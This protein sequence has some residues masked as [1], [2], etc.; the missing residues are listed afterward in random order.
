MNDGNAATHTPLWGTPPMNVDI[1]TSVFGFDQAGAMGNIMFVR[2][3]MINK[4]SDELDS[5]FVSMWHDDDVG[6]A[7]DD[8]VGCNID[9]SVGYTYNDADGDNT[10]GVEVPAAGADFFQGPLVSSPGDTST[11]FTWSKEKSYH[12]RDFP[13]MKRLG[14]TSFAKYIN[15][16][17]IF[18]D[19]ASAQETY[20][21]MNGLVGTTGEPFIDPTTGQPSIFVHDGDPTNGTGWLD[22]VP[23]DRRY[24]MTSGP[25]YFAPGDTQE[26]VGALILAAGSN[27]AKSITKMLYF[28][29]FA[30][31]AFDANF[32]VCSPPSPSPVLAQLDKKVILSFEEG[33]DAVEAYNCGSYEFQGYNVYQG[34]SFNGPWTRIKT[35]DVVD[36]E[37]ILLDLSLDEDTGELLEI[38]SQFGSDSGLEHYIEITYDKLNSR[39]LINNRKYYFS[40]TAYAYDPAAAQRVIESPIS[41]IVAVPGQPGVGSA[42]ASTYADT[43]SITHQSGIA[44]AVFYPQIVDP[45]LLTGNEYTISVYEASD[46]TIMWKLE[47]ETESLFSDM[48]LFPASSDYYDPLA[49]IGKADHLWVTRTITDGFL[50]TS[51]KTTFDAPTTYASAETTQDDNEETSLDFGGIYVGSPDGTWAGFLETPAAGSL[52]PSGRPGKDQLQLDIEIRFTEGGSIATYFDKNIDPAN[53]DTT[54][55]PFEVWTVED[56]RQINYAVFQYQGNKQNLYEYDND[57]TDVR[58][59]TKGFFIIP[60]YEAYEA[61]ATPQFEIEADANKLGWMLTFNKSSSLFETGNIFQVSFDNPLIPGL[62]VYKFTTSG[63]IAAGNTDNQIDSINVFPNPYFGQNPEERN[64]LNRFVFFTNLGVGKTTIRIFTLV[65]DQIRVIE[66]EI[67]S[68]NSADRRAQWD[69]RNSFDIPVASGM[70][71]AHVTVVDQ[72]G[73]SREKIMKLAVFMPEERLDVY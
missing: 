29:N 71:I 56:D 55:M 33:A 48:V 51:E 40:V 63:L 49:S 1:Q 4:G 25:F 34:A 44:N 38:P 60:A 22:D 10:Y 13:D 65:G 41:P 68:E 6:D 12:L 14:M 66:K 52:S 64:Q 47:S 32:N 67:A 72:A 36:G 53:V 42:L 62:D 2:W 11:I 9:L 8:L 28:D 20:N 61:S 31:A 7:T 39:D 35:F 54:W 37:K 59:F 5:V 27:W 73:A 21:Y 69:L 43:V 26:V 30:Q 16:N 3:V 18:S 45:Y 24:L 23:G 57:T 15:G 17:P 19:P 58:K 70:Y 46:S 50:L